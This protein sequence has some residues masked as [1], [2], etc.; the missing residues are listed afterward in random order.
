MGRLLNHWALVHR[1]TRAAFC[2]V[3]MVMILGWA[4]YMKHEISSNPVMETGHVIGLVKTVEQFSTRK[5][6][7]QFSSNI[8]FYRGMIELPDST[9]IQLRLVVPPKPNVGDKI[10]LF[11][12]RYKDGKAMYWVD[13]MKWKMGEIE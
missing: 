8:T 10:P 5:K 6:N 1:N 3:G 9:Q 2:L 12:E 4:L 7:T 11:F 13:S